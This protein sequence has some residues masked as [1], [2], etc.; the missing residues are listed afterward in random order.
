MYYCCPKAAGYATIPTSAANNQAYIIGQLINSNQPS[1]LQQH[2]QS[3]KP[4]DMQKV[5]LTVNSDDSYIQ[6]FMNLE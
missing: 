2:S 6:C 5:R 3:G 4:G 1:I